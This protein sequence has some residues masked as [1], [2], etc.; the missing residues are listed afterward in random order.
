MV[1]A[2]LLTTLEYRYIRT[3][4]CDAEAPG[5]SRFVTPDGQAGYS[6]VRPDP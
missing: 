5:P 1:P 6:G 2:N 4:V 3:Y